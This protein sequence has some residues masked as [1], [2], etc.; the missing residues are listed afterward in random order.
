MAGPKFGLQCPGGGKDRGT[1]TYI[2]DLPAPKFHAG[3]RPKRSRTAHS[4]LLEVP[5]GLA[6][7]QA[8]TPAL[9]A[10]TPTLGHALFP[11][12]LVTS[13]VIRLLEVATIHRLDAAI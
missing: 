12:L 9:A 8:T 4:Q 7:W 13:A 11:E 6:L 2:N 5:S 3:Y 1:R 10:L